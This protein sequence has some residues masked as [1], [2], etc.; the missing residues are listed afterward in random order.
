[1]PLRVNLFLI[2]LLLSMP[3]CG[4]D[5]RVDQADDAFTE[6]INGTAPSASSGPAG[7]LGR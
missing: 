2:L 6:L 5:P 1:M 3:S 7:E 4:V